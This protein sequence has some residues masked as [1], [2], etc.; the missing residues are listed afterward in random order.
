LNI[1]EE[2]LG[3]PFAARNTELFLKVTHARKILHPAANKHK[4]GHQEQT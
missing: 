4:I 2:G 1:P 3:W